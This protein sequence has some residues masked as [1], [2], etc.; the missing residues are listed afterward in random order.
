M[1][2]VRSHDVL[3]LGTGLAGLRAA[4]QIAEDKPDADICLVGKVQ[5]MRAHS[6][7][8]QGGTAAAL[9]LDKGD[10]L[11][12]HAW[13]TVRGADF[14]A[15]QDA[16][17]RF[18]EQAPKEIR[19]LDDWGL[20]WSRLADG[21]IQQRDFGGH[22]FP[23]ATMASDKTG[24]YEM[25]TL[26]DRLQKHPNCTACDEV[27]VTS[28]IVEAGQFR[29]LTAIDMATGEFLV[30]RAKSLLIASGGAGMLYAFSTYSRTV[31][32]DGI[33]MA[34][35]AGMTLKDME[36]V[37][38]HPTGLVPSGILITEGAR[39]EGGH[40]LN[41]E[42]ERFMT[43]YASS[44]M[45]L[46]PRDIISRAMVS[47]F[48][49]GRGISDTGKTD[50][51]HLH[52]NL[53]L[54]HLGAERIYER[55]SLIREVSMRFAGIDPVHEPIPVHP[56]AHYT[57]G[58]IDVD[59]DGKASVEGIWVAGEAACVSLHGANR[60]GTNSTAE[61]LVW[62]GICGAEIARYLQAEPLAL[63][64]LDRNRADAEEQRVFTYLDQ[65]S[66]G[67]NPY[68]IAEELQV[69]MDECLGV[70]RS[71]EGMRRGIAALA[72]LKARFEQVEVVNKGRI[73]NMNLANV[74]ELDN[75]LTLA[76]VALLS[77][78]ARQESRGAHFRTDFPVRDDV[79]WLQ[80]SLA[81]KTDS[82][83]ELSYKPVAIT[84]WQPVERKY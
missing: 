60:L 61:C 36:F 72:D 12:L 41:S 24:F 17:Y 1:T 46:A 47:E 62:G 10:S 16:V 7:C 26:Y 31:T 80:H 29:A 63:A 69:V 70:H 37:Q 75:L 25:Q 54:T 27:F 56:A 9:Q 57:M 44:K 71:E 33:A 21:R 35:N 32:G 59:I 65:S 40:L 42:G 84:H 78:V 43:R 34:Y 22:S 14:L 3:I 76:E 53:D 30:L 68:K 79:N 15:D 77:G 83:V 23:R 11:D 49:A 20:P 28:V 5:T 52:M 48:E 13:D 38:F 73:Y 55:L 67:E 18:V 19:L 6:V 50:H 82:G 8:A 45:E 64:A 2:E 66:G 4:T 58:G 39:G 81:R 51:M 74:L